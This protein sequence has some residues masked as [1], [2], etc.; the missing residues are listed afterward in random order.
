MDFKNPQ[1]GALNPRL[2][3]PP[4]RKTH[5]RCAEAKIAVFL[6]VQA[7]YTGKVPP[8]MRCRR[9]H[10]GRTRGSKLILRFPKPTFY[11]KKPTGTQ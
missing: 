5:I 4:V 3:V 10:V 7:R 9:M 6:R 1:E 8:G 11:E 2:R